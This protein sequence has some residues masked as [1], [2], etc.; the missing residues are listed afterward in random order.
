M[1]TFARFYNRHVQIFQN[2]MEEPQ[3]EIVTKIM[4][5]GGDDS[6]AKGRDYECGVIRYVIG[7]Q[8]LER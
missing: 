8:I 5:G 3:S 6:T 7:S 1:S 4:Q 2:T